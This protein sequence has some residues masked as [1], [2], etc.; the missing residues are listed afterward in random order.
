MTASDLFNLVMQSN[1]DEYHLLPALWQAMSPEH[2]GKAIG[3]FQKH[4]S[5]WNV[6]CIIELKSALGL[7]MSDL[8]SSQ[9]GIWL[10]I[11]NPKHIQRGVEDV[12]LP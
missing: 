5:T 6:E 8:H 1:A 10:A 12:N 7:A 3:I 4:E 11:E 9:V 2:K